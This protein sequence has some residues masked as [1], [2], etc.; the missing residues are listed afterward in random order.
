MVS[1][2]ILISMINPLHL[3]HDSR[4]KKKSSPE[5]K[6]KGEPEFGGWTNELKLEE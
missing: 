4:V 1:C 2:R 5:T 3:I 6:L